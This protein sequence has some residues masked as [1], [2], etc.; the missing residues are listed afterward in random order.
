VA[1]SRPTTFCYDAVSYAKNFDDGRSPV[2][3]CAAPIVATNAADNKSID[4]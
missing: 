2:P 1:A 4:N 3:P